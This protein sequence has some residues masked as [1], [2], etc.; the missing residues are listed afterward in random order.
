MD[1]IRLV[2]RIVMVLFLFFIS[3]LI[4]GLTKVIVRLFNPAF[5]DKL[6]FKFVKP[7]CLALKWICG[8][9]IKAEGQ[10][11]IPDEYGF[12]VVGNHYSYVEVFSTMSIVPAVPVSKEEIKSWPLFGV[13]AWIGGTVFVNRDKGGLSGL[14][15]DSLVRTLKKKINIIFFPE[16]TTTD[17]TYLKRFKSALFVAANQLKVPVLP[18]VST[19]VSI[20]GK[21][22]PQDQRD[23]IA[24]YGGMPFIPHITQVLKYRCVELKFK[25]GKPVIPDYDDSS[26][27]ER[28][29]F[30][31]QIQSDM[32]SMLRTID[33]QYKGIING[34]E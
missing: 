24:W 34:P 1:Y 26:L 15:I 27:E 9:R 3:A 13:A 20:N 32:D 29:T 16:G 17:G 25:I 7:F 30:A 18:T 11:N 28:R 2:I 22:V 6:I 21:P 31:A 8:I 5:A 14:Y 10:E 19:V 33:P 4:M 12:L 23:M